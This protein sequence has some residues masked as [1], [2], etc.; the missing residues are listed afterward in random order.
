MRILITGGAGYIGS[1]LVHRLAAREDVSDLV[2]YDNLSRG[3][4]LFT[5]PLP[6]G[7]RVRPRLIHGDLL[8]SRTLGEAVDGADV[9][10]HLAARVSTPFAH[11][12][13]HGFDQVNRWGAGELGL[14]VQAAS[15]VRRIV[16]A[17]STAVYGDTGPEPVSAADDAPVAPI[18]AYGHAKAQGEAMLAELVHDRHLHVLRLANTHGHAP[19]MRYQGLVNR[20]AFDA[21]LTGRVSVTG[22]G[23]QRRS[24]VHVQ[25]AARALE[26]AALGQIEPGTRDVVDSSPRVVDVLRALRGEVADLDIVFIS[27]HLTPPSSTVAQDPRLRDDLHDPRP[28]DAQV[29]AFVKALAFGG[30]AP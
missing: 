1:A 9:V 18:T 16:H 20:L 2:V 17:S 22:T 5:T 27:Q 12:D 8:D 15:S 3:R 4:A 30:P 25:S 7:A 23:E 21:W 6:A 11:D 10:V 19:A 28:L 14:A 26:A 29:R 13:L 24:V